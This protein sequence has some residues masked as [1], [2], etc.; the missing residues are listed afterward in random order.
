LALVQVGVVA[1]GVH[2]VTE[3]VMAVVHAICE[4]VVTPVVAFSV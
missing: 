3:L 4:V 1:D 2:A